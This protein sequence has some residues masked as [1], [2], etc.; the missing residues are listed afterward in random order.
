MR[1]TTNYRLGLW[2]AADEVGR[3]VLNGNFAALDEALKGEAEVRAEEVAKKAEVVFGMYTGHGT[4]ETVA[5]ELGFRP[6]ALIA[7]PHGSY[8]AGE[9]SGIYTMISIEGN[10]CEFLTL[11]DT[12]FVASGLMCH[13]QTNS[14]PYRYIAFR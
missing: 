9:G 13:A 7:S 6:R 8:N 14:N 12:G 3:E 10:S 11:T 5:V 2:E 4:S 1:E